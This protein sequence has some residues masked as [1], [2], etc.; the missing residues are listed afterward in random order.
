MVQLTT[1]AKKTWLLFLLLC[2]DI[3]WMNIVKI[4][5]FC[6]KVF[7][8]YLFISHVFSWITSACDY[9]S[10]FQLFHFTLVK[11]KLAE[12]I[13]DL[14]ELRGKVSRIQAL[15]TRHFLWGGWKWEC[16]TLPGWEII[17]DA[18]SCK[19]E[20]FNWSWIAF[21]RYKTAFCKK[22]LAKYS[23]VGNLSFASGQNSLSRGGNPWSW[24]TTNTA[25]YEYLL[26]PIHPF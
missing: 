23:I 22:R 24:N 2:W 17:S 16:K 8:L 10:I 14:K 9:V 20:F 12:T 25:N 26:C 15:Q 11:D 1:K 3:H 5:L 4:I 19:V 21:K 13:C 7:F 18:F 6:I